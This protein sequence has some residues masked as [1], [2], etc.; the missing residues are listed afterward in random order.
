M[1]Q[2]KQRKNEGVTRETP[3]GRSLGAGW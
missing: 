3:A 1:H 2:E